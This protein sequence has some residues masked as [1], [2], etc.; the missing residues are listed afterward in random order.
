MQFEQ[1]TDV[2]DRLA[3]AE[4]IVKRRLLVR[5]APLSFDPDEARYYLDVGDPPLTMS[6]RA[7]L[8]S[9]KAYNNA[10]SGL[11]NGESAAALAN[12]LNVISTNLHAAGTAMATAHGQG[13]LAPSA[14]T[15]LGTA[16][17]AVA[18]ALPI[19][20]QIATLAGREKFRHQLVAGFPTM[21]DLL[22]AIRDGTPAMYDL[23]MSRYREPG[24]TISNS[25]L[26]PQNLVDLER[27]RRA[28]AGWVILIDQTIVAMEL[29]AESAAKGGVGADGLVEASGE[30]RVL[31]EQIKASRAS[32]QP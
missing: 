28:L 25:G 29:A 23:M 24:S 22:T 4:R 13:A 12:R 15:F 30:I 26:S 19:F 31:A 18:V 32:Q 16:S 14:T 11:A 2:L 6:F 7:S 8:Q 5:R 3:A 9:I 17:A 27:D 20:R 1:G 21:R 10:L